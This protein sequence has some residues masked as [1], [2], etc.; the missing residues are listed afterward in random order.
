MIFSFFFFFSK[1]EYTPLY[2]QTRS[3]SQVGRAKT[4]LSYIRDLTYLSYTFTYVS[5]HHFIYFT[6]IHYP[7]CHVFHA[8]HS[9]NGRGGTTMVL[10]LPISW[11]SS[12][13]PK[14]MVMGSSCMGCQKAKD[15]LNSLPTYGITQIRYI[16][17]LSFYIF[18]AS[19]VHNETLLFFTM[20]FSVK[21]F[22]S[23]L[24]SPFHPLYYQEGQLCSFLLHTFIWML[25]HQKE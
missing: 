17:C 12:K 21:H 25:Y 23:Q 7:T 14:W 20:A 18:G 13:T 6:Y 9:T 10:T 1:Y 3:L 16:T 8:P 15:D 22:N 24:S 19:Q 4:I 2:T 5:S 11:K